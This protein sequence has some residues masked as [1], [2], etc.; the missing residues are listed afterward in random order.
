LPFTVEQ[1]FAVIGEYNA[2]VWPWQIGLTVVAL[3]AP[4]I[5]F[6]RRASSGIIIASI[7]AFLWIWVAVAYHVLHF[8]RINPL[9]YAFALLS[10][11]G[12]LA[13]L[14]HGVVHHRMAF[15]WVGGLTEAV[16]VA[17]VAYALL[18]YPVWLLLAGHRY[19]FTPTFGLPCPTTLFTVGILSFLLEPYPRTVFIVPV[20]WCT[21]GVQ[22][23]FLFSVPQD[24][25]LGLA[26]A[27]GL[28]RVF[29]GIRPPAGST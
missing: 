11:L 15:G 17:L 25:G 12:A 7:L 2:A 27:V 19:P 18:G 6:V 10:I 1:F 26:G 22:A 21:V 23:A 14:W 3:V 16:G 8:A 5:M 24:L 29:R 9:A 4:A 20:L 28:V 13:F